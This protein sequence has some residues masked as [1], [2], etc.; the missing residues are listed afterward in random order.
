MLNLHHEPSVGHRMDDVGLETSRE[1]ETGLSSPGTF[2]S[3]SR[4]SRGFNKK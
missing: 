3:W 1:F 4:E 2:H